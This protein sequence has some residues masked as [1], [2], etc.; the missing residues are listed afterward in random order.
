MS[1]AQSMLPEFDHEMA[2]TRRVLERVPE[3]DAAW[4]PH[5]KSMTLGQIAAHIGS[6]PFYCT[7][8]T[9]RDEFDVAAPDGAAVERPGFSTT[10]AL[11]ESFDALV[12]EAREGLA[13]ASDEHLMQ[14]WTLKSGGHTVFT[15]PRVAAIRFLA[16]NHIIHHRGQLSVYLRLRD[17]PVPSIYGPSADEK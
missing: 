7:A 3:A 5:A 6:A 8:A 9:S 1:I 11:L 16:L 4:Q 10:A 14:P 13:G 12:R 2:T 17:V 15:L